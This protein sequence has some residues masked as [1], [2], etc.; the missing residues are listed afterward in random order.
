M[1]TT[2]Y[3]KK[4]LCGCEKLY[5]G[6][7]IQNINKYKGSG[8]DWVVHLKEHN[9]GYDDL[10]TYK[11]KNKEICS[12]FAIQFSLQNDIR[13]NKKYF[14]LKLENGRD[15]FIEGQS[16]K[17]ETKDKIS[18]KLKGKK[19][20]PMSE[21][22]KQKLSIINKGKKMKEETKRKLSILNSGKNHPQYGKK[23]NVKK[24]FCA[25]CNKSYDNGN[26]I[27]NNHFNGFCLF[28]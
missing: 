11:F 4:C 27:K 19:K 14:N 26:Y 28:K 8:K 10:F 18:K 6:K 24:T 25:F 1:E 5:F 15:G 3:L 9:M 22:T 7:T 17:Q 16:R 23:K 13:K 21:E 20:K 2:L 12:W